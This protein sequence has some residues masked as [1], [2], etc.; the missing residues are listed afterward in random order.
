VTDQTTPTSPET[1]R[2]V[3]VLSRDLFFGMRIRTTL[4][5]LGYTTVLVGTEDELA[6]VL[7]SVAV[8]LGLV[9]F[10]APVDWDAISPS[11]AAGGAPVIA[12]GPHTD[13]EGF[14]RAREAG[15]AR[16]ISNGAF[17]RQLPELVE[18]YASDLP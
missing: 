15:A 8:V 4:R 6:R 9:D 10:N 5:Q 7:R 13:T 3:V 16:V 11:M 12:F 14:R 17:S 1:S 18:R 2:Q